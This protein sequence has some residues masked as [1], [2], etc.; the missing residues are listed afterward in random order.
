MYAYKYCNI[1]QVYNSNKISIIADQWLPISFLQFYFEIIFL[2]I[3]KNKL[4]AKKV[5]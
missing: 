4:L 2:K 1:N 5:Q 3:T